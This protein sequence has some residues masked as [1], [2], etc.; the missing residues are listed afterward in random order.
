MGDI[1]SPGGLGPEGGSR[2]DR[3]RA[4]FETWFPRLLPFAYNV[5]YRFRG[6]DATFAEDV[7]QA[8]IH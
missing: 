1:G 4:S 3:R 5:G 6:G 7:A 2:D 8:P